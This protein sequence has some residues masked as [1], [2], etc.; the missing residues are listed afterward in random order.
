M[1]CL[2]S[3][4]QTVFEQIDPF[5]N[6]FRMN[7]TMYQMLS[8]FYPLKMKEISIQNRMNV[9]TKQGYVKNVHF[10][11]QW[12]TKKATEEILVFRVV[13]ENIYYII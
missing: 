4:C 12:L 7:I 11:I 3:H 8:V 9:K 13:G 10:L 5:W 2:L 6:K 1:M